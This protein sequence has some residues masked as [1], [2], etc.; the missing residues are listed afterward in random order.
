MSTSQINK[1]HIL[2]KK[3]FE[4]DEHKVHIQMSSEYPDYIGVMHSHEFIEMVYVMSGVGMHT[5]DGK[6]S[7]AKKGDLFV[8]NSGTPHLFEYNKDDK[9]QFVSYDLKFTP[10]FFDTSVTGSQGIESLKNSFMFYSLLHGRSEAMPYISVSGDSFSVFGELFGKIYNEYNLREKGYIEIIRAYII[11]LI[12][13]IFRKTDSSSK[14]SDTSFAKQ[15]V[16]YINEYINNNFSSHI[17]IRELASQVCTNPDYMGR[18]YKQNT[19]VTISEMIQKVR[20]EHSCR[21]LKS[22]NRTVADVAASCG[23]EDVKFFYTVFKRINGISPGEYRK[24]QI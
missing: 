16:C 11:E 1:L 18:I 9:E 6:T 23:F 3:N 24:S 14:K 7:I 5:V 2:T 19:G 12:V 22:T 13:S 17:S 15:V 8:I 21:L 4:M 20:I 10:D